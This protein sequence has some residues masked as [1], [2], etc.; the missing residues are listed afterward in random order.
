[1]HAGAKE[2]ASGAT[3]RSAM[4]IQR[5]NESHLFKRYLKLSGR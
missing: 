1:M 3:A 4:Y 2:S 5:N